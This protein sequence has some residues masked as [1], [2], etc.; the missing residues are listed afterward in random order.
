[1]KLFSEHTKTKQS[2]YENERG[3]AKLFKEA[4]RVKQVLNA[5]AE[6]ISQVRVC[7]FNLI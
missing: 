7:E 3:L 6:T 2:I 4:E 1:V 5:N